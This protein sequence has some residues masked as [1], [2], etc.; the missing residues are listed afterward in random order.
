[1]KSPQYRVIRRRFNK[2]YRQ[3]WI[4]DPVS[5]QH[6]VLLYQPSAKNPLDGR[7]M[8]AADWV[9]MQD[10]DDA[11]SYFAAIGRAGCAGDYL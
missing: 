5:G 1:M 11:E 6:W 9:E 4:Q 10:Q 2:T 8:R 3:A 7:S